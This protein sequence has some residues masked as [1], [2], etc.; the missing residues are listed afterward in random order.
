MNFL[1]QHR[2]LRNLYDKVA[3]GERLAAA[4]VGSLKCGAIERGNAVATHH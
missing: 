4:D 2:E 1:V 3:A